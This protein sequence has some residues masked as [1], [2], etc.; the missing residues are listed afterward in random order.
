VFSKL[1]RAPKTPLVGLELDPGHLAAATVNL[2]GS[3]AVTR[4]AVA[5][6][7][8]G[9]LRDGELN[10]P[11]E[12]TETL[13]TLFAESELPTRVRLGLA[14]Q[15]IVVRPLDLPPTD[16]PTALAA[17]VHAQAPDH[18]PMPMDQAVVDFG[19][20]GV[21]TTP[22]GPRTRVVVVA[23][24]RELVERIVAATQAAGL[25]VEGI[26]L[27]AFAMVRAL[28]PV[29]E[30]AVL[31]VNAAGLTNVAVA[32]SAGCSF[33][34]AA[35]GGLDT[36]ITTLAEQR[37]L[38]LEHSRQ[39]LRHVGLAADVATVEGDP[40]VVA[41]ARSV[42][43]R[44]VDD[45]AETVRTSLNFHRV[46]EGSEHVERGV[47]VGPAVAIPGFAERLGD[48]LALPIAPDLVEA[49]GEEAPPELERLT[50]AAGLALEDRD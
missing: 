1:K 28:P 47:L 15:R 27:S 13:R 8:P 33:T 29:T 41:A 20:L 4:G 18:I 44:G 45:L 48:A 32:S 12:L 2:N 19:S 39:W 24:R 22:G 25:R 30:G 43:E 14:N 42:L 38:T 11:A 50:I 37:A 7:R 16:D 26:D 46:Q 31:Y 35:G 49:G 40:E 36:L 34:R 5:H 6:L 23:V 21:V 17:A 9:V 3:L 10:D